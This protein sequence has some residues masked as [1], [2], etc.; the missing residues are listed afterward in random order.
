MKTIHGFDQREMLVS[1]AFTD[2]QGDFDLATADDTYFCGKH[3]ATHFGSCYGPP[4]YV[5]L[6][7]LNLRARDSALVGLV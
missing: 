5:K 1:F 7:A 4:H 2:S 6:K 3:A